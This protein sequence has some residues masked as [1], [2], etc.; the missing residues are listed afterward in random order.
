MPDDPLGGFA[1]LLRRH[2][3]G[4]GMTQ[5]ALAERA[6]LSVRGISDLERG[7]KRHPHLETVRRLAEAL[8]LSGDERAAFVQAAARSR[9][10]R[11]PP[12]SAERAADGFALAM[13][14]ARLVGRSVELAQLDAFLRDASLTWLTVSGPGGV[15]KTRLAVE[16]VRRAGDAFPGGRWF[17]DLTA[18]THPSHVL[19]AIASVVAP[20]WSANPAD[21]VAR[22]LA[23]APASL[24]LLDNG[25]HV[26]G[27]GSEV[28]ALLGR[29]PRLKVLATSRERFGL[30]VEREW[31]LAPLA[32]PAPGEEQGLD[33]LVAC[34]SVALFAERVAAV[35][36]DFA[37]TEVNAAEVAGIVRGLDG[38][39]LAIELAAAR[40]K[41]LPPAVLARR[42]ERR[43]PLLTEGPRDLPER[44]RT[45]RAA[46][47][48]SHD[49]LDPDEQRAFR[50][51]AV[52][53]GGW[54]AGTAAT[55]LGAAGDHD[56]VPVL[57]SLLD[58][59]LI[60]R[61]RQADATR[62]FTM[63][64]TIREFA[65][66][67]LVASG[68]EVAARNAHARAFWALVEAAPP[69]SPTTGRGNG[70]LER[71]ALNILAALTWQVTDDRFG[72][73]VD[74]RV[75][76]AAFSGNRVPGTDAR[77]WLENLL[78]S[79]PPS[80]RRRAKVLL[81]LGD[82]A[83][84]ADRFDEAKVAYREALG[85][86]QA[87]ADLRL[88]TQATAML[89]G[90][91]E[92]AGDDV[93]AEVLYERTLA[94]ALRIGDRY[95]AAHARMNLADTAFR[96]GDLD[97]VEPLAGEA[98][99]VFRDLKVDYDA[100][101]TLC[102]LVALEIERGRLGEAASL[103]GQ[104][105]DAAVA[106]GGPW[107]LADTVAAAAGLAFARDDALGAARLLGAADRLL[108]EDASSR[109]PHQFQRD[110]VAE[111]VRHR[112]GPAWDLAWTDGQGWSSTVAVAAARNALEP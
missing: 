28:A 24:V 39:P 35:D 74:R 63:L 98:L 34:D 73:A 106:A 110:H 2:R 69:D 11:R 47:A 9:A 32:V 71:E 66:E 13:P 61:G 58:K 15:G 42:L 86:A 111:A 89:G 16:A 22:A 46:I 21:A 70:V 79:E 5:E 94:L 4:A 45:L 99:S 43:L 3:A 87:A 36:P 107:V 52:F 64:E 62:R 90:A 105:L 92:H 72:D 37:V 96:N 23:D 38:L 30:R 108:R 75:L 56:V 49:L 44:Q 17:V 84:A 81:S 7:A 1:A 60:V 41:V 25:E 29:V 78:A 51:L 10:P 26:L 77:Q 104:A 54:T 102:T 83:W 68:E 12:V 31:P 80:E 59:S 53:A 88:E 14:L 76:Q 100:A 95:W 85:I 65:L 112:L 18:V 57:G 33:R 93:A 82:L 50:W 101:L 6:G 67:Q 91:S 55:V 27:A 19:P 40:A 97:R 8:G 103:L 48:W 109:F 20:G